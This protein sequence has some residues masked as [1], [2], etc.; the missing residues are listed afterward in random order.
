MKR[1]L[2]KYEKLPFSLK[3]RKGWYACLSFALLF[4]RPVVGQMIREWTPQYFHGKGLAMEE[5]VDTIKV[6]LTKEI[7]RLLRGT[8][9]CELKTVS[10]EFQTNEDESEFDLLKHF[11]IYTNNLLCLSALL[12]DGVDIE[13]I[14]TLSPGAW[15]KL[16]HLWRYAFDENEIAAFA[17]QFE[18][19]NNGKTR[20]LLAQDFAVDLHHENDRIIKLYKTYKN[21]QEEPEKSILEALLGIETE[22]MIS[23]L[24]QQNLHII[25]KRVLLGILLEKA[26][27]GRISIRFASKYTVLLEEYPQICIEED[28]FGA[29]YA[30]YLVLNDIA[31][32]SEEGSRYVISLMNL[33]RLT[34]IYEYCSQYYPACTIAIL[35]LIDTLLLMIKDSDI[36]RIIIK[37]AWI[38]RYEVRLPDQHICIMADLLLKCANYMEDRQW[39]EACLDILR[40]A[41]ENISKDPN[42]YSHEAIKSFCLLFFQAIRYDPTF[43]IEFINVI[44]QWIDEQIEYDCFSVATLSIIELLHKYHYWGNDCDCCWPLVKRLGEDGWNDRL[45]DQ[46]M[47]TVLNYLLEECAQENMETWLENCRLIFAVAESAYNREYIVYS[48]EVVD[49]F[50]LLFWKANK[51]DRS[52]PLNFIHEYG[53]RTAKLIQ[54]VKDNFTNEIGRSCILP[55]MFFNLQVLVMTIDAMQTSEQNWQKEITLLSESTNALLHIMMSCKGIRLSDAWKEKNHAVISLCHTIHLHPHN[56]CEYVLTELTELVKTVQTGLTLELYR[57]LQNVA[58]I[59]NHEPLKYELAQL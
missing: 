41:R 19:Q 12:T 16:I 40:R 13:E 33:D 56:I 47:L 30:Y 36:C 23:S 51:L 27:K 35:K 34:S 26:N 31:T 39:L 38:D 2:D 20:W 28:D 57:E 50:F 1:H 15:N 25:A 43:P 18:V 59:F 3:D 5:A 9:I 22:H 24:D 55:D 32:F 7:P 42:C 48:D 29:M 54:N 11:A 37:F 58:E 4:H 14:E 45:S 10:G 52:F 8:A 49:K 6:F 53:M 44:S 17:G 46:S 21:L